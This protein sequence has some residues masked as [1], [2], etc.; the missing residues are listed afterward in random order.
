MNEQEVK[1][2]VRARDGYRCTKCGISNDDHLITCG[3]SLEVHRITPGSEYSVDP[4]ICITLCRTCHGPE[5][6]RKHGTVPKIRLNLDWSAVVRRLASKA[7]MK[8]R[9]Y[10]IWL[11]EQEAKRVGIPT[12][13][14]P[15]HD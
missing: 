9:D 5:P 11:L 7:N 14:R 3:R 1:R 2:A 10:L 6:R 8:V 13:P 12:P 4:G 15:F